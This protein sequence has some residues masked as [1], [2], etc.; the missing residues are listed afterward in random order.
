MDRS[1]AKAGARL[2]LG[3][4]DGVAGE[5][6]VELEPRAARRAAGFGQSVEVR[7]RA[8]VFRPG[9]VNS[10]FEV[11]AARLGLTVEVELIGMLAE[12]ESGQSEKAGEPDCFWDVHVLV[13]VGKRRMNVAVDE[14]EIL[15]HAQTAPDDFGR[16]A[17]VGR[18]EK[19]K[20]RL[21]EGGA[22]NEVRVIRSDEVHAGVI[23]PPDG[24]TDAGV[25]HRRD[26]CVGV[27]VVVRAVARAGREEGRVLE[28]DD[29]ALEAGARPGHSLEIARFAPRVEAGL[30]GIDEGNEPHAPDVAPLG[31]GAEDAEKGLGVAVVVA[32]DDKAGRTQMAERVAQRAQ[33]LLGARTVAVVN[34]IAQDEGH[35]G[36]DHPIDPMDGAEEQNIGH[37]A[38]A[39]GMDG[40]ITLAIVGV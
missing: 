5:V 17:V 2:V 28:G 16:L 35:V 9:V 13:A 36:P 33:F 3:K 34:E 37:V 20:G 4:D 1:D 25:S 24:E 18:F 8:E 11:G 29:G 7:L 38:P 40:F 30:L 27:R 31:R 39:V 22:D 23:V 15:G 26:D 6:A 21:A 14:F 10:R 12:A 19:R 32:G